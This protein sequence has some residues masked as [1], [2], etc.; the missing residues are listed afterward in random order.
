MAFR[1]EV[2]VVDDVTTDAKTDIVAVVDGVRLIGRSQNAGKSAEIRDGHAASVGA[3]VLIQD[4]D[5]E[6]DPKD[7]PMLPSP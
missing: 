7:L 5:I 2:I 3:I 6:Y 4:A 1:T